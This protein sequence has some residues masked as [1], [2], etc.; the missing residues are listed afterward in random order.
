MK[1]Q[2]EQE[3]LNLR[4]VL[5]EKVLEEEKYKQNLL[6]ALNKNDPSKKSNNR[7]FYPQQNFNSS[8]NNSIINSNNLNYNNNF[9]NTKNNVP[10]LSNF[11]RNTSELNNAAKVFSLDNVR[12]IKNNLIKPLKIFERGGVTSGKDVF[13]EAAMG[14]RTLIS[15]TKMIPLDI[16][17]QYAKNHDTNNPLTFSKI[18]NLAMR[19]NS[20]NMLENSNR[21][22]NI[23]ETKQADISNQSGRS[24]IIKKRPYSHKNQRYDRHSSD[25]NNL[26]QS[27]NSKITTEIDNILKSHQNELN[28]NKIHTFNKVAKGILESPHFENMNY[29]EVGGIKLDSEFPTLKD[30]SM[31]SMKSVVVKNGREND[32]PDVV[33]KILKNQQKQNNNNYNKY[34]DTYKDQTLYST[35]NIDEVNI[36]NDERLKEIIMMEKYIDGG[37]KNKNN[38]NIIS[39]EDEI[40]KLDKLI[41]NF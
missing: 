30:Q 5:K 26:E 7:T 35:L 1:N 37:S 40:S 15:D 14:D 36:R 3:L 6:L 9:N 28:N 17:D 24:F 29:N 16:L 21:Y 27:V 13:Q 12:E 33:E 8:D 34:E 10:D 4:Q 32:H 31:Y 20:S 41:K 38:L 25:N 11:K 22:E 19:P 18:G 23:F 39:E 2:A